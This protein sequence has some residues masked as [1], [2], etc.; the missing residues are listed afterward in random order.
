MRKSD[1]LRSQLLYIAQSRVD[2]QPWPAIAAHL[3]AG[4]IGVS[5]DELRATWPRLALGRSPAA[6]A[7]ELHRGCRISGRGPCRGR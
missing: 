1:A 7:T 6:I 3:S 4:G 5:G 2:Q